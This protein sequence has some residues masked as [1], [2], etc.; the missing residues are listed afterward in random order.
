MKRL[1]G[2]RS[3]PGGPPSVARAVPA[4]GAHM[5]VAGGLETA[6][7]RG[8]AVGCDCLQIFVKNQR[9]WQAAPLTKDGIVRFR[10]AQRE[11]G[12]APVLAHAGY[13]LNL[14]SPDGP[15]RK[16]SIL[17]LVDELERCAALGL[18]GLVLH[19]GAYREGTPAAGIKRVVK[20][21]DQVQRA[22]PGYSCKILL[23][24]TAGQGTSLGHRFGQLAAICHGVADSDRLGVCLDTCHLFAAGYDF[25]TAAGYAAMIDEL[26]SAIGVANV[27]CIH[28]NDSKRE[29]G[30]RVDRHEHIGKGRIGKRGF[31]HVV[32]DPRLVRV[33]MILET[34]K[35]KDGRGTDLDK[36]NLKRLRGL[37]ANRS[38]VPT[39]AFRR[40]GATPG[41]C[42]WDRR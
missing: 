15:I 19:P 35:G 40:P 6:F 24:T 16:R 22:C 9:Q 25:R 20:A 42:K 3:P 29:L 36:V 33:P 11:T 2:E 17:G 38:K 31:A 41:G 37:S 23:E 8:A 1:T 32:N 7:R 13:L 28:L 18:P 5:S 4:F 10:A 12:L 27:E 14:A 39:I 21:L 34:P 26:N 30:S